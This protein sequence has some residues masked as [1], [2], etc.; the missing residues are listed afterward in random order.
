MAYMAESD[1]N[2]ICIMYN[3]ITNGDSNVLILVTNATSKVK[4][5]AIT[6]IIFPAF[7]S[8]FIY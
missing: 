3:T 4:I 1:N 8:I 6:E 7:I 2:T 5:S